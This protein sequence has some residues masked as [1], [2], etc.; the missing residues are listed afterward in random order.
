MISTKPE[1]SASIDNERDIAINRLLMV[2]DNRLDNLFHRL[3]IEKT[4]LVGE[5]VCLES[6]EEALEWL[7]APDNTAE[8][9]LVDINMTGISGFELVERFNQS[10]RPDQMGM[11]IMIMSA[12]SYLDDIERAKALDNVSGFIEKP[13]LQDNVKHFAGVGPEPANLLFRSEY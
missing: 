1:P 6:S 9:M 13:L 7:A 10:A 11:T 12:S 4:G 3:L 2:D 5:V 8:V